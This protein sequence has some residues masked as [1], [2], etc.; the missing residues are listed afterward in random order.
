[1]FSKIP[2]ICPRGSLI[3]VLLV[4][5]LSGCAVSYAT[6]GGSVELAELTETD[7]NEVLTREPTARFPA[8]IAVARVQAPEYQ[9]HRNS[10]FGTG[11]YSV[12][13][14]RDVEGEDD[15][16]RIAAF[17]GVAGLGPLNRILLPTKLDSIKDLRIAAAQL[18]AD[19][20]LVYTFD[21]TF[22]VGQQHFAPLNLIA[23]GILPNKKVEVTTTASAA[24]FDVRTEYLYGLAEASA[25]ESRYASVW[26]STDAVDDLRVA[27]EK[28]AFQALVPEIEKAWTGIV[29][30]HAGQPA[31]G[32]PVPAGPAV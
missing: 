3:L 7:I 16:E 21:T 2:G 22:R 32:A 13:L 31:S 10:S 1:M 19:I 6:P 17:P 4:L 27:T 23:L 18:K 14:T 24:L 30:Q 9:S 5:A 15:F 11:R 28:E 8:N 29:N 26:G 20:L 25:Q 12:V